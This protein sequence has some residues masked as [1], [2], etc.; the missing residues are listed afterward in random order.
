MSTSPKFTKMQEIKDW[1][2]ILAIV[3]LIGVAGL[4]AVVIFLLWMPFILLGL[5]L[6]YY[7]L[8]LDGNRS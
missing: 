6:D 3:I 5:A 2:N 8:K 1:L 7:D 4:V